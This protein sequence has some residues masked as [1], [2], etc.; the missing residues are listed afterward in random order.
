MKSNDN[1]FSNFPLILL[2]G[3]NPRTALAL[4]RALIDHGFRVQSTP[5]YRELYAV[6]TQQRHSQS[7]AMVLLDVPGGHAVE[8]AVQTA[9]KFKRD[10]PQQ[11]VAYLADPVLHT[12]GLA[13][14]AIYPRN[15]DQ[16]AEA[17]RSQ[18]S[19]QA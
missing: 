13:G 7:G 2:A 15:A 11:F 8:A 3:D 16:L 9:L 17:L 6:W 10:D 19:E 4:Q 18:F 5:S 14:D 12:S 1:Q